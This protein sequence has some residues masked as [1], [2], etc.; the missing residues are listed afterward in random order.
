MKPYKVMLNG[1]NFYLNLGEGLAKHGFY[2][3]RFVNANSKSE[4]ELMVIESIRK[5]DD[6]KKRLKNDINDPPMLYAEEIVE[7]AS[8]D[9]TAPEPGL[10]WFK[11][12]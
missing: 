4:A 2:T 5:K 3:T 10:T 8:I 9:E 11:E 1:Q 6:I 7:I 12:E